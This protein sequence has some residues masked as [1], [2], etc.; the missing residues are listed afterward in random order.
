M[1]KHVNTCIKKE[2][3]WIKIFFLL[4]TTLIIG[5]II[6]RYYFQN[7]VKIITKEF[8]PTTFD[9]YIQEIKR[10]FPVNDESVARD[11]KEMQEIQK[12]YSTYTVPYLPHITCKDLFWLQDTGQ[13]FNLYEWIDKK[14]GKQ[15]YYDILLEIEQRYVK[16]LFLAKEM[17]AKPRPHVWSKRLNIP[18]DFALVPSADSFSMPSG[19]AIQGFLFGC[20]FYKHNKS[21]FDEHPDE[22]DQLALYCADHGLCRVI[23]GVH[24]MDDYRAALLYTKFVMQ[25]EDVQP[26]LDRY[27]QRLKS[28]L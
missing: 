18:I 3:M 17:I 2:Y 26:I 25:H 15:I 1:L 22:L 7:K 8:I 23:G 12:K 19:H 27:D 14:Y 21:Y 13:D 10:R 24:F 11:L 20:L 28:L 5:I 4:I 6:H 9:E 16:K